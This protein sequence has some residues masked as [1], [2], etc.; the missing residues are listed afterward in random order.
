MTGSLKEFTLKNGKAVLFKKDRIILDLC[1]GTGSWSKPYKKAGYDVR[2]ITLPQND[3]VKYEPPVQVYGVLAA[4]PCTHF[5]VSGAQFW[6]QKDKNGRT[7][8]DLNIVAHCC[9][10]IL[11]T[12]PKF[13]VLENPVGRLR[14]WL[15]PP[16]MKFDPCDYGDAYTKKTLLWGKF[17]WPYKKNQV[18]PEYYYYANGKKRGSYYHVKLGGK[19]E[20]TKKLRSVTPAGFANAFFKANR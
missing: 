11:A 8:F 7:D 20:R 6:E 19:S 16:V 5:T 18:Q 2:L 13:W 14:R 12:N 1:G 9:R 17:N 15:G 10:I 4:P 3:V